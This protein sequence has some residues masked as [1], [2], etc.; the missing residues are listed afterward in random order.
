MDNIPKTHKYVCDLCCFNTNNKKDLNRHNLTAKHIKRTKP[1]Q[2]EE[3]IPCVNKLCCKKCKKQY[4]SRSGLWS[5]L[6]IC[7][8]SKHEI[9][10]KKDILIQLMKDNL[11]I[12]SQI[13]EIMKKYPL[14]LSSF[15]NNIY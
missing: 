15:E 4:K 7:E 14:S 2:K 1:E 6:K 3:I 9:E 8:K 5:H 13:L 10:N 11:E 12:K